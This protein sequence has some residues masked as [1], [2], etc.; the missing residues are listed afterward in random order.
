MS[1]NILQEIKEN[2][3]SLSALAEKFPE[4][5]ALKQIPQDPQYHAE[6]DVYR[7]TELV[8]E[9]LTQTS[10]WQNLPSPEQELLFLSA[11]FHDIGKK[12]CTK[13]ENGTWISPKHTIVGEKIFRDLAYHQQELFGL[14]FRQRETVAK[15]IRFHGL[16]VWFWTKKHPERALLQAAESIPLHLLYLLARADQAGRICHTTEHLEEHVE[17]FADYAREQGVLNSPYPFADS[18]TKFQYFQKEDLWQGSQL[19]DDTTFDVILMAG[20]PLAGKDTW[21]EKNAGEMPVISLDQIREEL[22]IHPAKGSSKV[23]QIAKER[24]RVLLRQ[25]T[26]FIWNATN[27]IQETRLKLVQLFASYGARVHIL[28]LEVPYQELLARN[29]KRARYIPEPVL[30]EMIRKLEI[31]QAWEAYQ[32]TWLAE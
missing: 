6:G 29:K 13:Q 3:P 21:I 26:P 24:A 1:Q 32:V 22:G 30:E 8:C 7:H 12:A 11:A 15:L 27:I 31:P 2:G 23:V 19:Y 18:Y 10:E 16:P 17:L 14:T 20:L 28:Y 9:A 5:A 25:K 4:L